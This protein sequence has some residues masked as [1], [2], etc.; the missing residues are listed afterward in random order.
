MVQVNE[1]EYSSRRFPIFSMKRTL[2]LFLVSLLVGCTSVPVVPT[3]S[4]GTTSVSMSSSTTLGATVAVSPFG[5]SVVYTETPVS[6]AD[7]LGTD[8]SMSE[9]ANLTDME[10]TYGFTLNAKEKQ[11]LGN[12]KFVMLPLTET[13]IKPVLS[14]D[15]DHEMLGLYNAVRGKKNDY[16]ERTP[17]NSLFITTDI[18]FHSYNLLYTE[19]L[20]EM[21]NTIFFP[22]MLSLSTILFESANTKYVTAV[23]AEKETWRKVRNYMAIPYTL[24]STAKKPLLKDDYFQGGSMIDPSSLDES[25][26]TEDAAADTLE[27]ATAFI[28]NMHLDVAS[29]EEIL[30]TLEPLYAATEK[31]VPAIFQKE[32]EDYAKEMGIS[33]SVDF[34]QFTP[35]SHYTGSSLRRQYFRT[36][37]WFSQI[38]FFIK[39]PALTKHAFAI[40]QLLAEHPEQM[41]DY[42]T[43]ESTIN[44]LVGESD[45]LMPSDYMQALLES[46][47]KENQ[48]GALMEFL[49][50]A[51]PPKI[52]SMSASYPSVGEVETADVL[53]ATKGM[54]FF[55]GKFIIDSYW[56]GRLTQGDEAPLP[57][58]SQK[59]P[60]MASS[61]QVMSL[62][63][64]DYARSQIPTLDFYTP[65]T[66]LAIDQAMSELQQEMDGL[67]SSFWT[68]NVYNG[69]LWTI[70]SLFSWQKEH[71]DALPRFMQSEQWPV[72]TLQTAAGFWTELRHATLL[73]AKQSF[74]ELG[75]GGACDPR[76]IPTPPKGYIEPNIQAFDRLSYVAKTTE[77]GLKE[78]GFHSL[79]NLSSLSSFIEAIDLAKAYVVKQLHNEKFAEEVVKEWR[80][81][82]PDGEE[83]VEYSLE[84]ESDWEVLRSRIVSQLQN[85]LPVPVEGPVLSA[86]DKRAALIADIHTGQD[87]ANPLRILYEATGVPHVILVAVKDSNG[88]RLTIGFTYSQYEFTKEYGGPRMTDEDWQKNFYSGDDQ[89]NAFDYTKRSMWPSIPKWY[90]S[91]F[92]R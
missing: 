58:Y 4:S 60:P 83:C 25:F 15:R 20:K 50:K 80:G 41:K 6:I 92:G 44:F 38:P 78:M 55:S 56:T 34:T 46:K 72:K 65:E 33:F 37:M 82:G 85:S 27:S 66:K 30:R 86:K 87:S 79:Q 29:E 18:F 77:A 73:Y 70:R 42:A 62:L 71:H 81:E 74:A 8:F 11:M 24:L 21:E 39:S 19:L 3:T 31:G 7:G 59:L 1:E 32:Y 5:K 88:P 84:G 64:S 9:V 68:S 63:G 69:W 28:K 22:S 36:M 10:K 40:T 51:R 54:R 17:A 76:T 16:K 49:A 12:N 52:K 89:F 47:G 23:D 35:R 26:I 57:G 90:Q 61:L 13:S 2:S 45:D 48:E 75:G 67:D 53:L 43:L 91:L 14:G